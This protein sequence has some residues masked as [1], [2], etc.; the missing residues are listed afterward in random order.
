MIKNIYSIL[1][2][3]I[4]VNCV[5]LS[6]LFGQTIVYPSDNLVLTSHTNIKLVPGAYILPDVDKDGIFILQ[7]IHDCIIDGDSVELNGE[8]F[9]GYGIVI[10]NCSNVQ[11][12]NFKSLMK[13]FYA[14]RIEKSDSITISNCNFTG[15]KN[16]NAGFINV[17][18]D[19]DQALGGGVFLDS[20]RACLFKNNIMKNSN[21]GIA[22]YHC[23][24]VTIQDNDLS[25]NT[26]YAIRMFHSDSCT[27][28]RNNASHIYRENPVNSDA[29][30]ILMIIC[31]NNVVV[32][33]DFSYSSDGVFLC[34]YGHHLTPNKNYFADNDCSYSPHNAIEATFADGNIYKRN[35]CNYS[36]YGLWLGY[37]FN[38]LVDS[39]EIIG[40]HEALSVGTAGIAIDRGFNNTIT[41]NVISDNANGILLWE[42]DKITGYE[43]QYS[44]QYLIQNNRL[45]GNGTAIDIASTKK[46]SILFNTISDNA[47]GIFIS[48]NPGITHVNSNSFDRT[49]SYYIQNLS[50]DDI[51]ARNNSFNTDDS[52]YIEG[53]IYDGRDNPTY[54]YVTW[55]PYVSGSHK[56]NEPN[57]V[58]K[59]L[60][61]PLNSRWTTFAS[62]GRISR[63]TWDSVMM[64]EGVA[65]LK[66]VTESGYDVNIHRWPAEQFIAQWNLNG[67]SVLQFWVRAQN[68]NSGQFQEV[69][70]RLGN[71]SGGYFVFTA[72]SSVFS[73][74]VNQWILYQIPLGGNS[75]WQR[76]TVGTVSMNQIS[77]VEI[78]ADTWGGGFTLW[79]DGLKFLSANSIKEQQAM[80]PLEFNLSDNYPNPFNP[81]TTFNF[82]IAEHSH[83]SIQVY[84]MLGRMINNL[85][86]QSMDAGTYS[87]R[88]K[89]AS[90]SGV[91][92]VRLNAVTSHSTFSSTKK[93][94]F[95]K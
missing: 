63:V 39:N 69:S 23:N 51:D 48:G 62:D 22:L 28:R 87:Q 49:I 10:R 52:S 77:Y 65:S 70:I 75:T 90:G 3:A 57:I 41:N 24:S 43:N 64:K 73:N 25:Y 40:N 20:S 1:F 11:I 29:G 18:A 4:I 83:V 67:A 30:A 42:G 17:W 7:N 95:S 13:Y 91:Y 12:K 5:F 45:T 16:D 66:L 32:E 89:T 71:Q 6:S 81:S 80:K 68:V 78:H 44:N 58:L 60:T 94:I 76:K 38:S 33:N 92:F 37:S 8:S 53:M 85:V 34:Q 27:I 86:D 15:N 14:V 2:V 59:D 9:S 56:E 82:T 74:A 19:K 79:L 21:D 26:A 46:T 84:D 50:G 31:N 61:E 54:G 47:N 93:I 36:G 55:S 72:P 35:K 88:W